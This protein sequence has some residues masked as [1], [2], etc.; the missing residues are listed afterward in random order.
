[1]SVKGTIEHL[2][3]NLQEEAIIESERT[4]T[5]SIRMRESEHEML[6]Y[7]AQYFGMKKTPF[8]D[9][10]LR[11]AMHETLQAIAYRRAGGDKEK[12]REVFFELL[13]EASGRGGK[14]A[15]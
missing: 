12:A 8:A 14:E 2:L 7:L 15:S 5:F 1:M 6:T 13:D 10:L 11:E 4:M 9:L 3:D